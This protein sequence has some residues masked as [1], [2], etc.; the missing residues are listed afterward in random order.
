MAWLL[1]R[2]STFL[3]VLTAFEMVNAFAF[4]I[5]HAF[6]AQQNIKLVYA[7]ICRSVTMSEQ[8]TVELF[9]PRA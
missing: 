6:E 9:S 2:P 1:D 7:C 8:A 4:E 3:H 5:V